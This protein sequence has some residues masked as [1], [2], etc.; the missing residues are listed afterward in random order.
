MEETERKP[1]YGG[2]QNNYYY[3]TVE[4]VIIVQNRKKTKTKKN[5]LFSRAEVNV[6]SPGNQIARTINIKKK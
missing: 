6:N 4:K 1:R 5:F 2:I 3:G